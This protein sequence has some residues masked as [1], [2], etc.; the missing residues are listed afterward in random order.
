MTTRAP[1]LCD[2]LSNCIYEPVVGNCEDGDAAR[3][4]RR[5]RMGYVMGELRSIAMTGWLYIGFVLAGKRAVCMSCPRRVLRATMETT[6][7]QTH[8]NRMVRASMHRL[9]EAV[10]MGIPA[11]VIPAMTGNASEDPDSL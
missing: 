2:A 11:S 9:E 7:R 3:R 4:A 6:A 8:A 5:A 10:M 1:D